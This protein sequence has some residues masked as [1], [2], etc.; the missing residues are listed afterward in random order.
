M[1][2]L[3]LFVNTFI[4]L[5]LM[6][7]LIG[8]LLSLK[9]L[10]IHYSYGD[11]LILLESSF[12]LTFFKLHFSNVLP[13]F[14][15][16]CLELFSGDVFSIFKEG[17]ISL[18]L[19]LEQLVTSTMG[20]IIVTAL[21][22]MGTQGQIT[23]VHTVLDFFFLFLILLPQFFYQLLFPLNLVVDLLQFLLFL[24]ALLLGGLGDL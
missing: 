23:F 6:F 9:F 17:K 19:S 21:E 15:F 10:E 1:L 24:M 2:S 18:G 12:D 5:N 16:L 14:F 4:L 7:I 20:I 8:A 3:F 11:L 13:I 22:M